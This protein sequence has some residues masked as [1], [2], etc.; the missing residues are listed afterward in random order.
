MFPHN[1][2][3]C[4]HAPQPPVLDNGVTHTEPPGSASPNLP[5]PVQ[6]LA[7]GQRCRSRRRSAQ[8]LKHLDTGS[9]P[10]ASPTTSLP[11]SVTLLGDGHSLRS[12]RDDVGRAQACKP[13]QRW[14]C[15]PVTAPGPLS[16]SEASRLLPC[17]S[18]GPRGQALTP[19][20]KPQQVRP[21]RGGSGRPTS[22][23]LPRAGTSLTAAQERPHFQQKHHDRRGARPLTSRSHQE[24]GGTEASPAS[25]REEV[26]QLTCSPEGHLSWRRRWE[27]LWKGGRRAGP[28]SLGCRPARHCGPDTVTD[29]TQGLEGRPGTGSVASVPPKPPHKPP[30]MR[31]PC[32]G[33]HASTREQRGKHRVRWLE[34]RRFYSLPS[35]RWFK[36]C[37]CVCKCADLCASCTCVCMCRGVP[38][39][40]TCTCLCVHVYMCHMCTC[41]HVCTCVHCIYVCAC[42][43]V[44]T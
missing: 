33:P 21:G 34:E 4:T 7:A 42:V 29:A 18:P 16:S 23:Q 9:G 40:H 8:R 12:K 27:S 17:R 22:P 5:S 35:K 24:N 6:G 36:S 3:R 39:T 2:A 41:V 26:H 38:C 43:C 14:P 28:R 10:G 11:A 13:E 1:Q 37:L 32:V 25:F 15:S 31:D 20:T 19:T 30:A 44:Y